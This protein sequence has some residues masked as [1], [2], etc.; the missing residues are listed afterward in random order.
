MGTLDKAETGI[1]GLDKLSKGGLPRGRTTIVAGG[2]GSGKTILALQFLIQGCRL[3]KEP[4]IF[5]SFE[6]SPEDLGKNMAGFG[7]RYG[8]GDVSEAGERRERELLTFMDARVTSDFLAAGSFDVRGL[9]AI[10]EHKVE[11]MGAR[12]IVLDAIDVL[13]DLLDDP[14]ERKRE[15]L[16]I[17]EWLSERGITGIITAKMDNQWGANATLH[18][19]FMAYMAA[20]VILMSHEVTDRAPL[21]HLRI[22]KYRGSEH[23]AGEFPVVIGR[24]GMIVGGMIDSHL[25]HAVVNERV[26]TGIPGLDAMLG[27]G[28]HRGSG[29]LISG[30]PGT[31]K[32]S[33][34]GAFAEASCRAGEPVLYVSFDE[35]PSQIVRN[36]ASIGLDLAAHV[37]SGRL[38]MASFR[39]GHMNA[40]EQLLRIQQLME[41]HSP[42]AVIVDPVSALS[43]I[44]GSN[45]AS[46]ISERLLDSAKSRGITILFTS[47]MEKPE[48]DVEATLAQVS[49]LAD[50]WIQLSFNVIA[51]ER[52]RAVTIIKSR[53]TAHSNQVREMI[54]SN[55]GIHFAEPY[56]ASGA[57]LMGTARMEKEQEERESE[58]AR[59]SAAHALRASLEQ[60]AEKLM[61]ERVALERQYASV[62]AK[63]DS[64]DAAEQARLTRRKADRTD[65]QRSRSADAPGSKSVSLSSDDPTSIRRGR[66]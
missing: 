12:R 13:L 56:T 2:T 32:S 36:V 7:W 29:I 37:K 53:G 62:A 41:E 28:Y 50:T 34:A 35:S 63:L 20:S 26:T 55:S 14:A 18:Y 23:L 27:G 57:V 30:A 59:I 39:V 61:A 21:R 66:P 46:G 40:E 5:V 64:F 16:R 4:G 31:A 1:P 25:D 54:L 58:A 60:E 51:G 6:E 24:D 33:L 3:F 52:N 19:E 49:T 42:A 38:K 10:L 65:L 11:A 43:K 45:L 8:P 9:L 48:M 15:I 44:I 47:L 22:L 17:H